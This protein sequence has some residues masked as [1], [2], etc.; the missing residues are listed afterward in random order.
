MLTTN[1]WLEIE[2]EQPTIGKV[3]LDVKTMVKKEEWGIPWEYGTSF[4][5]FNKSLAFSFVSIIKLKY[6]PTKLP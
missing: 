1:M 6:F 2:F 4:E 5:G 3:S